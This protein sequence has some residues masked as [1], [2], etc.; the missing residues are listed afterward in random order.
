MFTWERKH[1]SREVETEGAGNL[2]PQKVVLACLRGTERS[3]TFVEQQ[4]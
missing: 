1:V 3:I 2:Q 4:A